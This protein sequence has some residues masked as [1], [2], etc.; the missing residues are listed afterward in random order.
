[1]MMSHLN[2]KSFPFKQFCFIAAAYGNIE[3]NGK[4]RTYTLWR[5]I[6]VMYHTK[7]VLYLEWLLKN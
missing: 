3:E 4:G 7:K 2:R 1:M 5:I 6:F